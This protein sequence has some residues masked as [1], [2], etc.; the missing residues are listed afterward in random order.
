MTV[1]S[2]PSLCMKYSSLQVTRVLKRTSCKKKLSTKLKVQLCFSLIEPR[3]CGAAL[4]GPT[5]DRT[6]QEPINIIK[7]GV[8]KH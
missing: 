6:H 2:H 1:N 5:E 3:Q 4:G 8:L 7:F